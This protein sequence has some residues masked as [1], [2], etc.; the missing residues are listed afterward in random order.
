MPFTRVGNE[1]Q[2]AGFGEIVRSI[3]QGI[4]DGQRAL[5]LASINTLVILSN[6]MVDVIPE[7]AEVLT[8]AG[9]NV[10][11]SG[12]GGPRS[13]QVTGVRVS[14]VPSPTVKLTAL[15]AGIVPTFYQFTE[16][17]ID[18]K[19]SIQLREGDQT[20]T[21]GS[22]QSGIFAFAS[23]VNF[24]TQNTYS[25]A[26]DASSSVHVVMRPVPPPRP[27]MP[28]TVTINALGPTP[29]VVEGP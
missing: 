4:A 22:R 8:P 7:I 28:T 16:A 21:D 15:Q 24:R 10:N 18:L 23:H 26:V 20:D 29:K 12:A 9:V 13:V 14:G 5:D 2:E 11:V 25:Y 3:A 17:T 27:T 1:L 19:L 6:T